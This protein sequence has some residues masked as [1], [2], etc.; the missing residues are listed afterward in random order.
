[1]INISSSMPRMALL[2]VS[3]VAMFLPAATGRA[4]PLSIV[5]TQSFYAALTRE[6]GGDL[7]ALTAVAKP[8]YNIHQI[9]PR[10]SDI[11]AVASA[12]LYISAGLDAEPWSEPLLQAAGNPRLFINA[13]GHLDLSHGIRMLNVPQSNISR[14]D[15]DIHVFGNPH[16]H[17]DPRNAL[18]MARSILA[19]L[20]EIDPHHAAEFA[21]NANAFMALLED[22]IQEWQSRCAHGHGKEIISYHNDIVY[23]AD[24]LGLKAT[25]QIEPKPGIPPS[26]RHLAELADYA[27]NNHI[28]T[29]VMPTYFPRSQGDKLAHLIGGKT[30]I[31]CQNVGELPGTDSIVTF[32]DYNVT[33]IQEALRA[34]E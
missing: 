8:K 5:A 4:K 17:M 12:D 10:P 30:V 22:K 32:Y 13:P 6:I 16:Y 3:A 29:I 27:R 24:F 25:R 9:Q 19:K 23:F 34:H 33:A 21:G 2:M 14:A 28:K 26:P 20:S 11:R 31:I 7:I 15:G 18:I 1:M